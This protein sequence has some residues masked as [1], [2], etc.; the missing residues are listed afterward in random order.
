MFDYLK[1]AF[2]YVLN[3]V[4][5]VAVLVSLAY[6]YTWAKVLL[7]IDLNEAFLLKVGPALAFAVLTFVLL[8]ILLSRVKFSVF[9]PTI[10]D[11]AVAVGDYLNF[12]DDDDDD[13]LD[14]PF[15]DHSVRVFQNDGFWQV[16]AVLSAPEPGGST[17]I[18]QF[19]GPDA[20]CLAKAHAFAA[21]GF[22]ADCDGTD[23]AVPAAA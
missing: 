20:E 13:L 16:E 21:Y 17:H 14:H 12:L 8:N 15:P 4:L 1:R 19:S 11:L 2:D 22:C 10:H 6:T 5:L 9:L 23:E 3:A 7:A 18:A